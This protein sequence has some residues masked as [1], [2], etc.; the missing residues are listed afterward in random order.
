MPPF[1]RRR[2]SL[3]SARTKDEYPVPMPRRSAAR[4]VVADAYDDMRE[5]HDEGARRTE[6][7]SG[8]DKSSNPSAP[9]VVTETN[10]RLPMNNSASATRIVRRAFALSALAGVL[11]AAS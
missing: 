3:D 11:L 9:A 10:G 7:G 8:S 1:G 2:V 4:T 6:A 5:R